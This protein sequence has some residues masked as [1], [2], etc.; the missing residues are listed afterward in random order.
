METQV[1]AQLFA[2]D[3]AVSGGKELTVC[4]GGQFW[5]PL[6]LESWMESSFPLQLRHPA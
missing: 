3:A 1:A 6:W 4:G 2:I 5:S